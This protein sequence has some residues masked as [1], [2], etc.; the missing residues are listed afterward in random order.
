MKAQCKAKSHTTGKQCKLSAMPDKAVCR[1]HGGKSTGNPVAHGNKSALKTG[2][3]EKIITSLMRTDERAAYD[4]SPT[5][6]VIVLETTLKTL[7]AKQYRIMQRIA[8]LEASGRQWEAT[9][10][11]ER[12]KNKKAVEVATHGDI[13]EVGANEERM[14]LMLPPVDRDQKLQNAEKGL[15]QVREMIRKCADSLRRAKH[16]E[17][18][19]ITL[20]AAAQATAGTSAQDNITASIV[21][22]SIQQ[23]KQG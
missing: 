2:A 3:Y 8:M 23:S 4:A 6:P 7:H 5:D 9:T 21:A 14:A 17:H 22:G 12:V 20:T 19:N 11:F 10:R 1:F 16:P 18:I 13:I 15:S